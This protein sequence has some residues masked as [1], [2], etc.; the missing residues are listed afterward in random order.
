MILLIAIALFFFLTLTP[1]QLYDSVQLSYFLHPFHRVDPSLWSHDWF[2]TQTPSP[3]PFFGSLVSLFRWLNVLP[4]ALFVMYV[5]QWTLLIV[6]IFRLCRLFS[7]D[8]RVPFLVFSLLLF[9]FSDGLGQS[10]LYSS[11]VQPTDLAMPFYLL[12]LAALFEEKIIQTWV[13]LGLAGLFHIHLGIDG[14]IVL[15]I[16]WLLHGRHWKMEK[17]VMGFLLFLLVWSPNL[18]PIV[19]NFSFFDTPQS[20]AALKVFF[21]F[22]SPH[23]YRPSTFELSHVFRVLFPV[24]FLFL[25]PHISSRLFAAIVSCLA[26]LASASTEWFYFPSVAKLFLFRLSP[27]LLLL[28]LVFLSLALIEEID[29]KKMNGIFLAAIT[30]IVLYLEKDSRLFIPLSLF[31]ALVWSLRARISPIFF[32]PIV[33]TIPVFSFWITNRVETFILNSIFAFTMIVL[34]SFKSNRRGA[35]AFWSLLFLGTPAFAFH[36]ISPNR[37]PFHFPVIAPV[38]SVL[39]N[40]PDLDE[41]LHWIRN[42][43]AKN[44]LF[45][46]PPYL[47]G[48]RFFSERSIVV[49]LH[50]N[51]YRTPE[52]VEWK[53]RLEAVTGTSGLEKWNP[54]TNDPAPQ[55]EFLRK[56]YLALTADDIERIKDQYQTDYFL[57]ESRFPAREALAKHGYRPVYTN[58]SYWVFQLKKAS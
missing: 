46:S 44:A 8:F 5:I 25:K 9:Y 23:H 11:I 6:G 15:L 3:H 53:R 18:I 54:Q 4:L 58:A 57:T 45:L 51:P 28:G 34:L 55:R 26:L 24:F 22:R 33:V 1:Y 31:L 41:T 36:F 17:M 27:L 30:F 19:K 13:F 29:Q 2:V 21:N 10:T 56:G 20:G 48:I 42:H 35:V 39:K 43:T 7:Q 47:D 14:L 40:D 12:S 50:A 16:F 49:D 32:L 38:S 37:A 52:W